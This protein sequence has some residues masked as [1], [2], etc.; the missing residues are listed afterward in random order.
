MTKVYFD[1]TYV[2]FIYIVGIIICNRL[3]F[4]IDSDLQISKEFTSIQSD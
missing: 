4:R 2:Y 1:K 3:K